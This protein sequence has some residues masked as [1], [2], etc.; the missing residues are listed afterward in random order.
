MSIGFEYD[1]KRNRLAVRGELTILHAAEALAHFRDRPG[2]E[3]DLGEV[4]E[5]DGAGLQ[6]LL[7]T[8][9]DGGLLVFAYGDAAAEVLHLAGRADLME[10]IS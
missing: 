1:A 2:L 3:L 6:L 4:T 8:E 5:M 7:A 10:A 9:R